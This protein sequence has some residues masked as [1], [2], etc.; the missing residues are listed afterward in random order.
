[1]SKPELRRPARRIRRFVLSFLFALSVLATL[2]GCLTEPITGRRQ[3][4]LVSDA[5]ANEM[6]VQAYQQI[7]GEAKLSTNSADNDLV[8]RVGERIAAVVDEKMAG[9]EN[10]EPFQWEFKVVDDPNMVNA[11]AL[12][13]GKV[14]FY[15]GILPICQGEN[16]V[17]VVMGHEVAHAYAR[18]GA[19]RVSTNVI[20]Q[21]SLEVAMAALGGD[22]ASET[23]KLTMAALGVGYQLGV[24][25]PFSRGDESAADEIGLMVMAEAGYDPRE[26]VRFWT[27]MSEA[28]GGQAPPEF[29]STH[30][31]HETRVSQLQEL[32]P[33]AM[34]IYEKNRRD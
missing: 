11:F 28:S 24:Q 6:G 14:A 7:L 1:M 33:R 25:L 9:E 3:L 27:R 13:G 30:P 29:M 10:R 21:V 19:S 34:E 22:G 8:R 18:H 17:A 20:S 26:A 4:I 32:M 31:G 23:A 15:S 2:T 12:P 5:Q 16:G